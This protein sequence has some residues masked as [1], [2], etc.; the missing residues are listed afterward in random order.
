[1]LSSLKK[2]FPELQNI[3][4]EQFPS[5][6]VIIPDGNGRWAQQKGK[7]I[8][9]G[10]RIGAQVT[11]KILEDLSSLSEVRAVTIWGF[12]ADNWKRSKDEVKGLMAIMQRK[13]Q[14]TLNEVKSTG[15]RFVHLGR[16]DRLPKSLLS[17]LE[18]AEEETK[19]NKGQIVCLA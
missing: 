15:R 5:H 4:S 10:H 2:A 8:L 14:E 9:E 12:S 1:M 6:I 11:K 7:N 19:N 18:K 16:K 3:S 17:I 13:I